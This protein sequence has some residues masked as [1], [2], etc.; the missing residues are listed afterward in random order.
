M[1]KVQ[2]NP[3][4]DEPKT[5]KEAWG[6]CNKWTLAHLPDKRG[7]EFTDV[8]APLIRKKAGN[9]SN[10]WEN[11]KVEDIQ[12]IVD[13]VFGVGKY[14]VT[15]DGPWYGLVCEQRDCISPL[16]NQITSPFNVYVLGGTSLRR[17]PLKQSK[18]LL[19]NTS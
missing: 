15:E 16:T 19:K 9:S 17:K 7:S 1:V 6:G 12:E 8:I 2:A 5:L 3:V 13:N 14:E 11:P 4:M 10:P 18:K